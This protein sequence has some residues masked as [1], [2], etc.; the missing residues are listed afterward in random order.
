M[1]EAAFGDTPPPQ[2][3][4]SREQ[5]GASRTPGP[6]SSRARDDARGSSRGAD[7]AAGPESRT[8]HLTPRERAE[9]WPLG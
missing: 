1:R 6:S 5:E 8:N 2:S 7:Q 9:R 3:G 4:A